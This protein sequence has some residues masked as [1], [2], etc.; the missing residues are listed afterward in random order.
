MLND[1]T[2]VEASRVLGNSMLAY[3]DPE[4]GI[5]DVFRKLTGRS[6]QTEEL[7]LLAQLREAEFKKFK[8]NNAKTEGWLKSG[9]FRISNS[10]DGA[11]VAANAVVASTIMNSDATITKR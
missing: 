5:A 6:I 4:Q 9:E 10:E 11:L 7:Q 3:S 8:A 2:Y 1:P